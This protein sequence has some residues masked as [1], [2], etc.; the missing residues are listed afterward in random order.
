MRL[1]FDKRASQK[2]ALNKKGGKDKPKGPQYPHPSGLE[3]LYRVSNGPR[4]HIG[5][6]LNLSDSASFL[7]LKLAIT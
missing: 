3:I 2:A 1:G 5:N 7:S 6:M 4:L